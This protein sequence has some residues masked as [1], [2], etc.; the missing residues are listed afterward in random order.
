SRE[1]DPAL[2]ASARRGW[3][4]STGSSSWSSARPWV[5]PLA[6]AGPLV[7]AAPANVYR[8]G[9]ETSQVLG[10]NR[11][12]RPPS[13]RCP[14]LQLRCHRRRVAPGHEGDGGSRSL[15]VVASALL[16]GR[17]E[18]Q[19][20]AG[21]R[22]HPGPYHRVGRPREQPWVGVNGQKRTPPGCSAT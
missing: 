18:K 6:S 7:V 10:P 22:S 17:S 13:L 19:R 8:G 3:G 1:G 4:G 15:S 21:G 5:C 11:R 14:W 2:A 20:A 9:L 12:G 16:H